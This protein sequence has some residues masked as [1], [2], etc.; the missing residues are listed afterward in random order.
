MLPVIWH[1]GVNSGRITPNDAV[2]LFRRTAPAFWVSSREGTPRRGVRRGHR[3]VRSPET[4]KIGIG[5]QHSR[6]GY[7]LYEGKEVLGRVRTVISRG[8]PVVHE[9]SFVGSPKHGKF[10]STRAGRV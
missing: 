10:L 3:R 4:W 8:K 7:T 1:E 5:N 2:R 9:G 6:V